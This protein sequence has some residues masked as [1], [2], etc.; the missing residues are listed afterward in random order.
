LS[1]T[2]VSGSGTLS[3]DASLE[4][5]PT[6][7]APIRKKMHGAKPAPSVSVA[8]CSTTGSAAPRS[9]ASSALYARPARMAST[10]GLCSS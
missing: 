9:R 6:D 2:I 3:S 7:A 8:F 10:S 5:V 4:K 1:S